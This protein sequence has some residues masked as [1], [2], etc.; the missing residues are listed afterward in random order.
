MAKSKK[1]WGK[2]IKDVG[3]LLIVIGVVFLG[4]ILFSMA[5]S[6]TTSIIYQI[7]DKHFI[8]LIIGG[9]LSLLFGIIVRSVGKSK[10]T[11]SVEE[12]D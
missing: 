5:S 9:L 10:E 4:M 8:F 12:K 6:S 1:N 3:I 2:E 7:V 11:K